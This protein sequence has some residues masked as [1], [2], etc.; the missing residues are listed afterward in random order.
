VTSCDD[1]DVTSHD[2][3]DHHVILTSHHNARAPC[4]ALVAG[5]PHE[6]DG[7]AG[8]Q[9]GAEDGDHDDDDQQHV[10]GGG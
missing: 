1:D 3:H 10:G 8:G 5:V 9:V 6:E 4:R 7:K 2:R